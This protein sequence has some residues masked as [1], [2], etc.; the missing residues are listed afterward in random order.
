MQIPPKP[1]RVVRRDREWATLAEF[2]ART[3]DTLRIAVVSGR[4]RHG[5]SFL[6][7]ALTEAMGG[8]YI[9]AVQ[10][11]GA[12]AAKARFA[13]AIAVH[14]GLPVG[15]LRLDDWDEL[16]RTAFR[17]TDRPGRR[18]LVVIDE[19]PYLLQHS[20]EIPGLIQ[21]IYD[22]GQ[23]GTAD[24][25]RGALILCGSALSVMH[26]LL[27]G[28]KPL[29]GRALI[30]MR[31][32][33]FDYREARA[34]WGIGDAHTAFLV[35]AVLG[36][37]PGY[38]RL[39]DTDP[40]QSPDE[41]P[42]WVTRV[43]LSPDRATYS[44]AET[45]YLLREDPRIR[46]RTT[47]Y[48]LL[49]AIADGATTPT[50]IGAA[51]GRDRAATTHPLEVLESAGYVR[52]A[53][54][55]LKQRNPIITLPDPV[56]RFNQ[57]VTLPQAPLIDLGLPDRAWQ[58]A[59]HAFHSKVLGP[60]FEDLARAYTAAHLPLD[61]SHLP[62]GHTGSTEVPD[63]GAR[64]QHE[65]DVLALAPGDIPRKPRRSITLIGEAKATATPRS[66][67]DLQRLERIRQLLTAQG[68]KAD[69][70]TLALYSLNGFWPDL[71]AHAVKRPDVLLVD[72][73]AL[74]GDGPL[75]GGAAR[76]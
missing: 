26:E 42:T 49:T 41:F 24:A 54:D 74:Y 56:I 73:A 46:Q 8:L 65:V 18:P 40:P 33:A 64:T 37:A 32:S 7:Q 14:S 70:A 23:F 52:R 36:G 69:G 17:A 72:L 25:P 11:D 60:H 53:Q 50:A 10:E 58:A 4:R 75:R 29:R 35:H 66:L 68:H 61:L 1:E 27:S 30:D 45:E 63:A 55:V 59:A 20:P 28:Q 76:P 5:K 19:L 3:G 16:L 47:Y 71:E 51:L 15:A 21:R 39:T 9:T 12:H 62:I 6:L 13:Q 57:V 44:R 2:A 31:L 48:E 67:T 38:A 34:F 22:E 43:L